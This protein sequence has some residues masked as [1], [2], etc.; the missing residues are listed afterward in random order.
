METFVVKIG[1]RSVIHMIIKP[2]RILIIDEGNNHSLRN[3]IRVLNHSVEQISSNQ[4]LKAHLTQHPEYDIILVERNLPEK[5]GE[6]PREI[7]IDLYKELRMRYPH[8]EVRLYTAED[9]ATFAMSSETATEW[10]SKRSD[11]QQVVQDISKLAVQT[12]QN[13]LNY[14][15]KITAK[16]NKISHSLLNDSDEDVIIDHILTG[17]KTLGFDRVRLAM[18]DPKTKEWYIKKQVGHFNT[19]DPT[20]I[21]W[22]VVSEFSLDNP[23]PNLVNTPDL[24]TKRYYARKKTGT[25]ATTQ[26]IEIPLVGKYDLLGVIA[27]DTAICGRQI[28]EDEFELLMLLATHA[29]VALRKVQLTQNKKQQTDLKQS[30]VDVSLA[31][32][33]VESD[34]EVYHTACKMIFDLFPD[35]EHSGLVV[36]NPDYTEGV[37]QAEYPPKG[38]IKT[39][40]PVTGVVSEEKLVRREIDHINVYDVKNEP[41][42]GQVSD[43]LANSGI[44]S[45]L[46]VP[47]WHEG[48][49]LG[50]FSLDTLTKKHHF[51]KDKI[52]LAKILATNVG[53]ALIN[54]ERRAKLNTLADIV[55][56]I[57][58][59]AE[60]DVNLL[61]IVSQ[62]VQLLNARSGGIALINPDRQGLEIIVDNRRDVKPDAFLNYGEGMAGY[63]LTNNRRYL[64]TEDYSQEPYKSDIFKDDNPFEAMIMVMLYQNQQPIGV[65]YVDDFIGRQFDEDD[66][67]DLRIFASSITNTIFQSQLIH[68]KEQLV[69]AVISLH[70]I[71]DLIEAAENIDPI[72][73][74]ALNGITATYG[75]GFDKAALLIFDNG[76]EPKLLGGKAAI[77]HGDQTQHTEWIQS[78]KQHFQNPQDYIKHYDLHNF[79]ETPL[80]KQIQKVG[81]LVSD[82]HLQN[83]MKWMDPLCR[84]SVSD[85]K[86]LVREIRDHA[87]LPHQ[88]DNLFPDDHPIVMAALV[89]Q[90]RLVGM[91]LAQNPY[92]KRPL[93][94]TIQQILGT[95]ATSTAIAIDRVRLFRQI[96]QDKKRLQ[97]LYEFGTHQFGQIQDRD[98]FMSHIVQIIMLEARA[99]GVSL[100]RIHT[101]TESNPS[102]TQVYEEGVYKEKSIKTALNVRPDGQSLKV[103]DH[104]EPLIIPDINNQTDNSH[105]IMK[106][107][108]L[109][110]AVC[111]PVTAF[112]EKLGVIWL[113][114]KQPRIFDKEEIS[115][116]Q[117]FVAQAALT[118]R[119]TSNA[120][121]LDAEIELTQRISKIVVSANPVNTYEDIITSSHQTLQAHSVRLYLCDQHR[122]CVAPNGWQINNKQEIEQFSV[123]SDQQTTLLKLVQNS[124]QI[125][126]KIKGFIT[127]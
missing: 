97:H 64:V 85:P 30:L 91:F 48:K 118:Y 107:L 72:F 66:I 100:L 79:Y 28:L 41:E 52:E 127:K 94:T 70:V 38:M 27:A 50:S 51:S 80:H 56:E 122:R 39:R 106:K 103:I 40:I 110:A 99:D 92:S 34:T 11:S 45:I 87:D 22:H 116:W 113:A 20:A 111:L 102:I 15:Q 114:Y 16:I 65:L 10:L 47:I 69:N 44:Q 2:L 73:H 43:I 75:L 31:I 76:N 14:Y 63:M 8:A 4:A 62:A 9:N 82:P 120:Q 112:G 126:Y 117:L 123:N 37:V 24:V 61:K 86:K 89:V 42:L 12:V 95:F 54:T 74:F 109:G 36:F 67:A 93:T 5:P 19:F 3:Q 49:L 71:G 96:Q 101:N 18:I 81:I 29:A 124:N 23:Q 35:V 55:T 83:L 78:N 58:I 1:Y 77:G 33:Q 21:E 6:S 68:E 104:Q 7:G 115:A 46:I 13:K 53:A 88:L 84:F 121:R 25:K 108:G 90:N 57:E 59:G 119:L 32:S 60:R 26:R 17:F 98:E 105:P 125:H